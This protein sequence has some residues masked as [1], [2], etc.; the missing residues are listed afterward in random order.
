MVW[1]EQKPGYQ[2]MTSEARSISSYR[3]WPKKALCLWH[4]DGESEKIVNKISNF[5]ETH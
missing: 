2:L 1:L 5:G 4:I 3:Y